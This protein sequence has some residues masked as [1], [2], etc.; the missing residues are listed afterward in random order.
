MMCL[1]PSF[2]VDNHKRL[3]DQHRQEFNDR[4]D[5]GFFERWKSLLHDMEETHRQ[6]MRAFKLATGW[7]AS[8]L[9]HLSYYGAVEVTCQLPED[10]WGYVWVDETSRGMYIDIGNWAY[11]TYLKD[12]VGPSV[13]PWLSPA[14]KG[15]VIESILGWA[16]LVRS[17]QVGDGLALDDTA[18]DLVRVLNAYLLHAFA[19]QMFHW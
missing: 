7:K 1:L 4:F 18:Q 16:W 2:S 8:L 14:S 10:R 13:L 5:P 6:Q 15:D 11:N 3:H 17:G 19:K 9:K 12:L